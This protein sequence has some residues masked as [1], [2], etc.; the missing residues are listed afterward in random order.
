M[1]NEF[2]KARK[3]SAHIHSGKASFRH[4][5]KDLEEMRKTLGNST[6]VL[7]HGQVN[8]PVTTTNK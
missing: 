7:G 8:S 2:F 1:Q 3:E 5:P 6:F 4:D